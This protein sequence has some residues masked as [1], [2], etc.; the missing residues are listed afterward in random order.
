[1]AR[2]RGHMQVLVRVDQRTGEH[3]GALDHA[4]TKARAHAWDP[5]EQWREIK[6]R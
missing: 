6:R 1:V 5:R 2:R 4:G 3:S